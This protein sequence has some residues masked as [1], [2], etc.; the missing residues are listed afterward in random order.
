MQTGTG[1]TFVAS[2][3]CI[4]LVGYS[5]RSV[6]EQ[7]SIK[8]R[9]TRLLGKALH[10]V[11]PKG[12][13]ILDT[14]DGALITFLG[15]PEQCF[16]FALRLRDVMNVAAAELGGVGAARPVRIGIHLGSVK[17]SV[18]MSG[19][20]SMVGDGI[21]VAERLAAFATPGQIVVSRSFHDVVSRLSD[22][23][24][25]LF[26][27]LGARTDK[28]GR[29]HEV[30]AVAE[31]AFARQD[32]RAVQV[33]SFKPRTVAI[34]AGAALVVIASIG[35][36]AWYWLRKS[37]PAQTLATAPAAAPPVATQPTPAPRA[38]TQPTP[39]T[40]AQPAPTP[41][42]P[43]RTQAPPPEPRNPP[44]RAQ[45]P[46]SAPSETRQF[47][48]AIGAGAREAAHGVGAGAKSL[49]TNVTGK[50]SAT[51]S[52]PASASG[53]ATPVARASTTF[54]PAAITQGIH[55]GTV[56]AR[57]DVD[58][59]GHVTQVTVLSSDPPRV[60]D[61]EA[62]RSLKRWRFNAGAEGRTYDADVEF[63]R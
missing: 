53:T 23:H 63:R 14:G 41:A 37:E 28:Q 51:S 7:G 34:A 46:A 49:W 57:L 24:A 29:E 62:V 20:P 9:F 16:A 36:A 22:A 39:V 15:D 55:S 26:S 50:T 54:P 2:V 33:V 12:R 25:R 5:T 58:A 31:Q 40:A 52:S 3:I 56:R 60:F 19:N 59:A 17:V 30:F 18:G 11:P 45:Q 21:N 47:F 48:S 1:R 6:A 27:P 44:V 35:A 38:A 61:D 43:P 4:D 8:E 32:T 42:T 10:G 13:T